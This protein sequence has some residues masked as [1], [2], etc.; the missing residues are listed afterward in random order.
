MHCSL[1]EFNKYYL[2]CNDDQPDEDEH[3]ISKESLEYVFLVINLPSID[4]VENL[5]NDENV[6]DISHMSAIS[7]DAL[8]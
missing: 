7:I 8:L 5:E 3:S 4:H 1:A 6:E 2:E